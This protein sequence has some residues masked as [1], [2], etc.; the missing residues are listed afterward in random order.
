MGLFAWLNRRRQDLQLDEDDF[1]EEVRAHLAIAAE[2]KTADGLDPEDARYAALR[3]FGNVTLT[4]ESTR[5]VWTPRWLEGLRNLFADV[6]YAIRTLTKNPVFS[7]SVI[8]VL[9]LG[10]GLNAAVFT[11][12]KALALSPIAGVEGSGHLA[13]VFGE[14]GAGRPI[15]VSY[16]DY[17]QLR[18]NDEAF[19][20][21][22]GSI[23]ATVGLGRGRDSRTIWSELVS[24]NYFQSLGIRAQL[25]RTLLPSDEVAPGRNPVVVISD[26][27]WRRDFAGDP[28]IVGKTIEINNRALAVVGVADAR[29]HG[30]TVVYDVETYI[31]V[32]MAPDLGFNFGSQHKTP[33]SIMAD[34]RATVFYPMGYLRPGT[35]LE[36]ATSRANAL[37]AALANQRPSADAAVQLRVAPFRDT[38]YGAPSYILPTLVVVGAMGL[39]VLSIACANISGLVLVRGVSRRGEIAL[40]LALGASRG[41]ILRLLLVENL[42]L[43]LPGALL[44]VLLAANGIP[45]LVRYAEALAAPQRVFFNV[46][47]DGLVIA[48]TALV[49]CGSAILFGFV[50]ALQSTKVDLV[51]VINEDASPRGVSRGRLRGALVVAQVAVSVLLLV[52]AGL[53]TRT[54]EAARSAYPG[55][56][57]A[58]IA[59][60]SLDVKHNGYDEIRGRDFYRRLIEAARNDARAESVTLATYEPVNLIMT[61]AQAVTIQGYE[62]RRDED[63]LF[64]SNVVGADYFR[65]LRIPLLA[66]REF[67]DRDDQR[68]AAVVVVNKTF[69][70]R[71]WGNPSSAIGKQ[72]KV[73]ESDW[74][75]VI[76]VA[77]DVKYLR[78]DESPRPYFYLPFLQAYRP[79]MVVHARGAVPADQL[80]NRLRAQVAALDPD[81]PV[82][83]ARPLSDRIKGA[84]IFYNL[85]ATMLTVF[86][87]TG[88]ALAAMGIYGLV[89]YVVTQ[90]THEIGIRMALGA[91]GA[92]IVCRF[93]SRGV[94]LGASG[95]TLGIVAAL[96][97]S[98]LLRGM[99]FGVSTTDAVSFSRALAIVLAGVLVATIVPAWRAARTSPLCA[100]RHN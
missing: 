33:A 94:R 46:G 53:V 79:A 13:V 28:G 44:G 10:I 36:H 68:A 95:A 42:V 90:S 77:A 30:T 38:P 19:S 4:T 14:T 60:V 56:D 62:P 88:L 43:A 39:L 37:W 54:L 65:T 11:M 7:L 32:M 40:R 76:G 52:G 31:P 45:V 80:S 1:K 34:P 20:E 93:L 3:E 82:E 67:E 66:G 97:V 75:T 100:L 48:F 73:G 26:G 87:V 35:T 72:V 63:L 22:F 29:F 59:T 8:G 86:G 5:Q 91:S 98:N 41:R 69:A 47:V 81:L 64:L 96:S 71:F 6:T 16:P 23:V 12:V 50:P 92:S 78:I 85:A 49:A 18:D 55:F 27:L 99:L 61:R 70:E 2:E 57:I 15:R 51:S 83:Y 9:T 24:G 74:R 25:G 58:S 17:R 21:L 89:S 84:T